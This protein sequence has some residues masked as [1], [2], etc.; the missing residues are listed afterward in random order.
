MK[1]QSL[2]SVELNLMDKIIK[3]VSIASSLSEKMNEKNPIFKI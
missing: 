2:E 1:F 3:I